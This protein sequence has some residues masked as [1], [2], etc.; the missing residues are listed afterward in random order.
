MGV[1]ER[2]R[3]NKIN[4]MVV[5]LNPKGGPPKNDTQMSLRFTF[6]WTIGV[7]R[8]RKAG[9]PGSM[10]NARMDILLGWLIGFFLLGFQK[11]MRLPEIWGMIKR[12]TWDDQGSYQNRYD[13]WVMAASYRESHCLEITS[14][15]TTKT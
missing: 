10:F 6:C 3:R 8:N 9:L 11:D 15:Q 4:K 7:C 2:N 1:L 12:F 13:F 14:R 5:F